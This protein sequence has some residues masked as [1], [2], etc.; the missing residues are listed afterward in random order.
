M[1]NSI[2]EVKAI[3]IK[4][5]AYR[6]PKYPVRFEQM[7]DDPR[8]LGLGVFAVPPAD[9]LTVQDYVF[10]LE[11]SSQL[12]EGW[13]LLPLVRDPNATRKYYQEVLADW[14]LPAT[15]DILTGVA[16]GL[17]YS[18][19]GRHTQARVAGNI[20]RADIFVNPWKNETPVC[21]GPLES[22]TLAPD[23]A[24]AA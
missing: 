22:K 12:P 1:S 4:A 2:D 20:N 6:F 15:C 14:S 19:L 7:E 9:F 24:L 17:D 18:F 16:T 21:A 11:M 23:F 10:D 3:V 13:E 8:I 5:M